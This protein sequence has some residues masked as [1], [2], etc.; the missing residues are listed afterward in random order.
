MINQSESEDAA[1]PKKTKQRAAVPAK[2]KKVPSNIVWRE[3]LI[4]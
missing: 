4:E 2:E 1:P 3:L